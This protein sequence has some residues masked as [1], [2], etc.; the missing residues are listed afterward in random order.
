MKLPHIHNSQSKEVQRLFSKSVCKVPKFR[1][2]WFS[3]YGICIPMGLGN[4]LEYYVFVT[5]KDSN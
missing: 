2:D 1:I 5:F 3:G 4:L